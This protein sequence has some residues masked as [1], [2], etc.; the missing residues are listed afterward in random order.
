MELTNVQA[1]LFAA[2]AATAHGYHNEDSIVPKARVFLK[3]L[4]ENS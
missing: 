2:A 3:F 1:A 4:N